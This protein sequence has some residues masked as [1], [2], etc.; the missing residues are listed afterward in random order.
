M[1]GWLRNILGPKAQADMDDPR[2]WSTYDQSWYPQMSHSGLYVTAES[3]LACSAVYACTN[4]I[5]GAVSTIPLLAHKGGPGTAKRPV[6]VHTALSLCAKPNQTMTAATF[7]QVMVRNKLLGGRAI[8]TITWDRRGAAQSLWP[9]NYRNV[10]VYRAWELGLDKKL[11]GVGADDLF[12]LVRSESGKV[13]RLI[14]DVDVLHIPNIGLDGAVGVSAVRAGAN[15]VGMAMAAEEHSGRFFSQGAA[16]NVAL[17]Y[18]NKLSTETID[19]IKE[20]WAKRQA[21]LKNSWKPPVITEGGSIERISMNAVDA[22]LIESRQFQVIDICRFFGVPPV[23]IGETEKTSSWGSGV[24]QMAKWF[25]MFTVNPHLVSI[26][27][28]IKRKLILGPTHGANAEY[29]EFDETELTRGDTKTRADFYKVARGSMQEPGFMTVNEIRAAEN[30]P[31][32]PGGDELMKP[33]PA[34]APQDGGTGNA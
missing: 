8:A 1:F 12:F 16:G 25:A 23:M 18:P 22:Q 13:Q 26:E 31:P 15:A 30:L 3:A 11:D 24:E 32:I 28:E 19:Q 2:I 21:G 6:E 10:D 20:Q 17:K 34:T 4:L 29:V 9:V 33:A 14:P 5:A 7:W 27:Q